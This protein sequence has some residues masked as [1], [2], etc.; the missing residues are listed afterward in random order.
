MSKI[1]WNLLSISHYQSELVSRFLCNLTVLSAITTGIA[2]DA[3]YHSMSKVEN[4]LI[5]ILIIMLII[6]GIQFL[7]WLF[8][9]SKKRALKYKNA[10]MIIACM[11]CVKS[12]LDL[13]FLYYVV[14]VIKELPPV[15][16]AIGFFVLLVGLLFKIIKYIHF[17]YD[18]KINVYKEKRIS[19]NH[20]ITKLKLNPV[21][22]Y[23]L[24][25][26]LVWSISQHT[27]YFEDQFSLI[28][29]YL[30][31]TFQISSYSTW[32]IMLTV[33]YMQP[34][35]NTIS[36][37][38]HFN[39]VEQHLSYK[40][41]NAKWGHLLLI[42]PIQYLLLFFLIL[43][44]NDVDLESIQ[45]LKFIFLLVCLFLLLKWISRYSISPIGLYYINGLL[46]ILIFTFMMMI[47]EFLSNSGPIKT[48]AMLLFFIM[49]MIPVLWFWNFNIILFLRR[50]TN[51]N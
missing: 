19:L 16:L 18:K 13:Y 20:I 28:I 25:F 12:V 38:N 3:I 46:S 21:V 37:D 23:I 26:L 51:E 15:N 10:Q 9:I 1:E 14:N 50:V 30:A 48:P 5:V 35:K 33:S 27:N 40:F 22:L 17:L 47:T 49:A 8:F 43:L 7:S 34:R 45:M 4:S 2:A 32:P 41:R 42:K 44:I 36:G 24:C 11:I 29:L 6:L 31:F 39:Q